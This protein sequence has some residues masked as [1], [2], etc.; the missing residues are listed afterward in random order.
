MSIRTLEQ[1]LNG[2]HP[3]MRVLPAY[4]YPT[5]EGHRC[6]A[7]ALGEGQSVR[8][9]AMGLLNRAGF[10]PDVAKRVFDELVDMPMG[11]NLPSIVSVSRNEKDLI[12]LVNWF[13]S[14]VGDGRTADA[15][16]VDDALERLGDLMRR[17]FD[18]ETTMNVDLTEI[19]RKHPTLDKLAQWLDTESKDN[20][21]IKL[22]K[23]GYNFPDLLAYSDDK[24][25]V[26][27]ASNPMEAIALSKGY[28]FC[29]GLA[30]GNNMFY[31]YRA[32]PPDATA[33]FAWF[34]GPNGE[35]THDNMCVVHVGSDGRYRLTDS[36]NHGSPVVDKAGLLRKY[37]KLK[38]AIESGKLTT[39]PYT[40]DEMAVRF[41]N[42]M[43][44]VEL[45]NKT[46]ALT[47]TSIAILIGKGCVFSDEFFDYVWEEVDK[48]RYKDAGYDSLI[49]KYVLAGFARLTPHQIQVLE[50]A[51]LG[52]EAQASVIRYKRHWVQEQ[53]A[54]FN[55]LVERGIMRMEEKADGYH[56]TS[57]STQEITLH[58]P[59]DK[60]IIID[61]V[62]NL[63]IAGNVWDEH[64]I[65]SIRFNKGE[66][67]N[68]VSELTIKNNDILH[69]IS[70]DPS[71]R[72]L[73][74]VEL[75]I[76]ECTQLET[77]EGLNLAGVTSAF[78]TY[79]LPKL[80]NLK[81]LASLRRVPRTIKLRYCLNLDS[82]EG[83]ETV[84]RDE[85]LH[86]RLEGLPKLHNLKYMP[87][88][89]TLFNLKDVIITSTEGL[90]WL[91]NKDKDE[92]T[93]SENEILS[94]VAH[95]IMNSYNE[96]YDL[97]RERIPADDLAKL[98]PY[99]KHTGVNVFREN[100]V[101]YEGEAPKKGEKTIIIDGHK[102]LNKSV[103][104]MDTSE[105]IPKL[106]Y[107]PKKA[108]FL[109]YNNRLCSNLEGITPDIT[110]LD[111]NVEYCKGNL[112]SLKGLHKVGILSISGVIPVEWIES[113]IDDKDANIRILN[114]GYNYPSEAQAEAFISALE[115]YISNHRTSMIQAL[116]RYNLKSVIKAL[117]E[118]MPDNVIMAE[119]Q[120][121]CHTLMRTLNAVS[122]GWMDKVSGFL[123]KVDPDRSKMRGLA[124]TALALAGGGELDDLVGLIK[125]RSTDTEVDDDRAT[126]ILREV[127]LILGKTDAE[128]NQ[129]TRLPEKERTERVKKA[130]Q[131][132]IYRKYK[133]NRSEGRA[134]ERLLYRRIKDA[135]WNKYKC[136]LG[137]SITHNAQYGHTT[138]DSINAR[139]ESLSKPLQ[140]PDWYNHTTHHIKVSHRANTGV[141][142]GLPPTV[143]FE[144]EVMELT[145]TES[146]NDSRYGRA[147]PDT[148]ESSDVDM[149]VDKVQHLIER[150][151]SEQDLESPEFKKELAKMCMRFANSDKRTAKKAFVK[152][153][154]NFIQK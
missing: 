111:I 135:L 5:D 18:Y 17:K 102:Y 114:I 65:K 64:N 37:P 87:E 99:V 107:M 9:M 94:R 20:R 47:P 146:D 124:K 60:N 34:K 104:L 15:Q 130:L 75:N 134:M 73:Y 4:T 74:I 98:Y 122:E 10:T 23:G 128:V 120:T 109:E 85:E 148:T 29:I 45:N 32:D 25:D 19:Q 112:H 71:F 51:G 91:M 67:N 93:Y 145:T 77:L 82:L 49:R 50:G 11:A 72:D 22:D 62:S 100:M 21:N 68:L 3:A 40:D 31:S 105:Y 125:D 143:N 48:G 101:H 97:M 86:L 61:N 59:M 39:D 152:I 53:K 83:L 139:N 106:E 127:S 141:S 1:L 58:S 136:T 108:D 126:D 56:I 81:G 123:D 96:S 115:R 150:D 14:G 13:L 110:E 131:D 41:I 78:S 95:A 121:P 63:T 46:K 52:K 117:K 24:V 70:F 27:K 144:G 54:F 119:S 44:T 12:P 28:T 80:R 142:E 89:T 7:T 88:R 138:S 16:A 147:K 84:Y 36:G 151:L 133:M 38:N 26:Y 116:P 42:P 154:K 118:R 33:Y 57:K 8:G 90:E 79:F 6:K 76:D 30:G 35:K 69:K 92:L 153:L 149:I 140:S 2:T 43:S 113:L 66:A 55:Q 129:F 132:V 137:E 103:T